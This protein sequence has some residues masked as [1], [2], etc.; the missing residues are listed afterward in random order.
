MDNDFNKLHYFTLVRLMFIKKDKITLLLEQKNNKRTVVKLFLLVFCNFLPVYNVLIVQVTFS[1]H[2]RKLRILRFLTVW[3][4]LPLPSVP[5]L[6]YTVLY[7]VCV[8]R[9]GENQLGMG[10]IGLKVGRG[11]Q[12]APPTGCNRGRWE[13]GCR[14]QEVR[15]ELIGH[16]TGHNS[17][18]QISLGTEESTHNSN[19]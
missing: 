17:G 15:C 4:A 2:R 14:C 5:R 8:S 10:N 7:D 11:G 13:E 19:K 12:V 6:G 18:N 9:L 1:Y 16:M 3:S